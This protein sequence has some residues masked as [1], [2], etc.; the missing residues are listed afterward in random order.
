VSVGKLVAFV[1]GPFV[2]LQAIY[3]TP[4]LLLFIYV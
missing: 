4:T 1:E 2:A 3:L